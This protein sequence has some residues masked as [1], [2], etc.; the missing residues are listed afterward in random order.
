MKTSHFLIAATLGA[1]ASTAHA[2]IKFRIASQAEG[3]AFLSTLDDYV[4]DQT[5]LE[6]SLRRV[7]PEYQERQDY[8]SFLGSHAATMTTGEL[9]K[10]KTAIREVNRAI[11]GLG[12]KLPPIDEYLIIK[13]S[14]REEFGSAYTRGKAIILKESLLA[15][16]QEDVTSILAHEAFH[17]LSRLRPK[18]RDEVYGLIGFFRVP[19]IRLHPSSYLLRLTNPDA[20]HNQY[21]IQVNRIDTGAPIYVIPYFSSN[22]RTRA[23]IPAGPQL[24]LDTAVSF[25]LLEVFPSG[26]DWWE[27]T[28]PDGTSR[29][30]IPFRAVDYTSRVAKNTDYILHPEEIMAD[31]FKLSIMRFLGVTPSRIKDPAGLDALD[32]LLRRGW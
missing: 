11:D 14:G 31:H 18:I 30:L 22:I 13:T 23:D 26:E 25:G 19:E 24:S 29:G 3:R 28:H 10:V 1:L 4:A 2:G 15:S 27:A 21:A 7:S 17:V 6:R 12:Y 32:A 8:L 9:A 16:L 5:P 20:F